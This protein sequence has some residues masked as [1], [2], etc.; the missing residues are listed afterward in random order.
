[1]VLDRRDEARVEVHAGARVRHRLPGP[2][3]ALAREASLDPS[4]L[5][6]TTE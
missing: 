5:A 1:V 6:S 4:R 2:Q 3:E